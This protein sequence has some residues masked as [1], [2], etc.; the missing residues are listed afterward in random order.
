MVQGDFHS[1]FFSF[2]LLPSLLFPI[3]ALFPPK[4]V[5]TTSLSCLFIDSSF[6][7]F[8]VLGGN[9]NINRKKIEIKLQVEELQ[10]ILGPIAHNFEPFV[11]FQLLSAKCCV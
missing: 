6:Q 5:H 7:S 1:S 11:V 8:S 3:L 10:M 9:R 4:P 2:F